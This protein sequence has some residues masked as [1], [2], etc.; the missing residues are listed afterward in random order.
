MTIAGNLTVD[1][2][3]L[4]LKEA[5]TLFDKNGDGHISANELGQVL[6]AIGQN[7]T[8]ATIQEVMTKADKDGVCVYCC[9]ECLR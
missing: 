9:Y 6:R 1:M 3:F 5:F 8:E 4:E 2:C 7:P